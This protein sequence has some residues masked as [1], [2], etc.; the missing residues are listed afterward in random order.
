MKYENEDVKDLLED[1]RS[2]TLIFVQDNYDEA[3]NIVEL[4]KA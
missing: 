4:L 3:K 1:I 2:H